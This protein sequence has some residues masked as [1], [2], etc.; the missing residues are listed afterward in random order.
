M[1]GCMDSLLV[2]V[3]IGLAELS[4]QQ[5]KLM[6]YSLGPWSLPAQAFAQSSGYGRSRARMLHQ[7]FRCYSRLG[8]PWAPTQL[9]VDLTLLDLEFLT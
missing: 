7:A 1:V 6:I 3:G 8:I 9:Y 2:L 4:Q 5:E